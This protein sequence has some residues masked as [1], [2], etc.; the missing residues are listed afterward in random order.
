ML[1]AYTNTDNHPHLIKYVPKVKTNQKIK[2]EL[3]K[4]FKVPIESLNGLTPIAEV[5]ETKKLQ[6]K[7][8][9]KNAFLE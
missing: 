5:I 1:Y 7:K 6:K 2:I 8:D 9:R 3:H 4:Q